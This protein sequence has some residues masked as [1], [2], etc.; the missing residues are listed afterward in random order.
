MSYLILTAPEARS[1]MPVNEEAYAFLKKLN[2]RIHDAA[3]EDHSSVTI[4]TD[5]L[6][7]LGEDIDRIE[8]LGDR[9]SQTLLKQALPMLRTNGFTVVFA[10][11]RRTPAGERER[12]VQVSW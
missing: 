7:G 3:F 5:D 8:W 9:G 1:Y 4:T 12:I 2:N 11:Q 10:W 6:P